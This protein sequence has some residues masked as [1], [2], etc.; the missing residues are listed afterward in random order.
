MLCSVVIRIV[1]SLARFDRCEQSD[2][3]SLAGDSNSWGRRCFTVLDNCAGGA[4]RER[5]PVKTA[6]PV[7]RF[8]VAGGGRH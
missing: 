3:L 5:S 2:G 1:G 6:S 4:W 8:I 7:L